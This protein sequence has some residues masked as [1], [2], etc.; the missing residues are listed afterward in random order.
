MRLIF[1]CEILN[2]LIR[3]WL[4]LCASLFRRGHFDF[5]KKDMISHSTENVYDIGI[6]LSA[7]S[8]DPAPLVGHNAFL[9]Y[10]RVT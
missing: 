1:F 10:V 7:S 8:G 5:P 2:I 9:R 4:C 6:A 3:S